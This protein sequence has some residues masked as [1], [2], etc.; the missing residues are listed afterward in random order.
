MEKRSLR[1][2]RRVVNRV[3]ALARCRVAAHNAELLL[4]NPVAFT[5]STSWPIRDTPRKQQHIRCRA[6][7]VDHPINRNFSWIS[8]ERRGLYLCVVNS[9]EKKKKKTKSRYIFSRKFN[10]ILRGPIY[11]FFSFHNIELLSF[12]RALSPDES[13]R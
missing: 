7:N 5:G 6:I 2:C 4:H 12:Q 11:F 10:E 8:I 3:F 13:G 9:K 1:K